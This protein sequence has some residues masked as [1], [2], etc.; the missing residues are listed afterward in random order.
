MERRSS[1]GVVLSKAAA[2]STDLKPDSPLAARAAALKGLKL[3]MTRLGSLT[4]E[5]IRHLMQL[6]GLKEGDVQIV[7]IGSP[8]T[9]LA[10]LER[11]EVDG[12]AISIPHDRFAA[13]GMVT[14]QKICQFD[15]PRMRAALRSSRSAPRIPSW[16]LKNT[17]SSVTIAAIMTFD[18]SVMPNQR[19][20][21]GASAM[22]GLP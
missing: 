7:A 21:R 16:V 13:L 22:R 12:F 20:N 2:A 14:C 18:A 10:A 4:D 8:S 15:A 3:G 1:I 9:L 6:G 17:S 11:K 5:G 19:T